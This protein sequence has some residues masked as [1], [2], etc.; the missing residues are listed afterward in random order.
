MT[1]EVRPEQGPKVDIKSLPFEQRVRMFRDFVQMVGLGVGG[2]EEYDL[3]ELGRRI[4]DFQSAKTD[5]EREERRTAYGETMD[6][7][8]ELSKSRP[9]LGEAVVNITLAEIAHFYYPLV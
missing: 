9:E 5:E 7:I 1:Q 6:R 2:N 3:R 4:I 8:G